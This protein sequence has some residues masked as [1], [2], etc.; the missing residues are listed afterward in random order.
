MVTSEIIEREGLWFVRYT[1]RVRRAEAV[2][3]DGPFRW[4]W[5]ARFTRWLA[6]HTGHAV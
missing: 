1:S 5:Y 2:W 3:T 4:R 6:V